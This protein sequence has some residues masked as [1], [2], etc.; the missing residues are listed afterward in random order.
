MYKNKKHDVRDTLDKAGIERLWRG[1]SKTNVKDI[2]DLKSAKQLK[3][4][5]TQKE[6]KTWLSDTGRSLKKKLLK[7]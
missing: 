6:I 1:V 5:L 7:S 3:R 4:V 2:E